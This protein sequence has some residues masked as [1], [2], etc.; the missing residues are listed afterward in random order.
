MFLLSIIICI[1]WPA[2]SRT[3]I[4]KIR[5]YQKM[6]QYLLKGVDW[7]LLIPKYCCND[8]TSDKKQ[9]TYAQ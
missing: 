8:S 9:G 2:V 1:L 6:M 4:E 7:W 5:D 3:K